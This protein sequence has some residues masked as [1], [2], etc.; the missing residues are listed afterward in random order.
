MHLYTA[1]VLAPVFL[2]VAVSGGLYLLGYKGD[3]AQTPI[4]IDPSLRLDPKSPTLKADL[5]SA[6]KAAGIDFEFEY[7]KVAGSNLF[8]RPTSEPHYQ[9]SLGKGGVSAS[10]NEPSL[11]KRLI[12]LHKGHGPGAFKTFQKL[13]AAGL[14]FV[15]LSGF[16]LGISSKGLR[17][18]TAIAT[19]VGAILITV[20]I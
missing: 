1:A 2:L 16:W 10:Y 17:T 6:L 3:V 12:E 9:F 15:V 19:L 8:T 13:T 18:P 5:S 14:L 20:L 4:D 11:Q 7:V